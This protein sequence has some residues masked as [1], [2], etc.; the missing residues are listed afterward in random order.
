[1]RWSPEQVRDIKKLI[2]LVHCPNCGEPA[3]YTGIKEAPGYGYVVAPTWCCD[4]DG[5]P[6]S[7]E[8][9]K[10]WTTDSLD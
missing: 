10:L 9:P 8:G 6:F 1:M 4:T 7:L 2:D 5:C 3:T